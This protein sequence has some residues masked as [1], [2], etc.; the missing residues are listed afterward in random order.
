MNSVGCRCGTS[1]NQVYECIH[2]WYLAVEMVGAQHIDI[3]RSL[4]L[5]SRSNR[6]HVSLPSSWNFLLKHSKGKDFAIV[7]TLLGAGSMGA[8]LAM[9]YASGIPTG[10]N[11]SWSAT[12]NEKALTDVKKK[13]VLD[14]TIP[15]LQNMGNNCFLN[16]VLQ[17]SEVRPIWQYR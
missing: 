1:R 17:V 7:L 2:V 14:L 16:V 5:V 15:G 8:F 3:L 10:L 12:D 11:F 9:R 4:G 13:A 6:R